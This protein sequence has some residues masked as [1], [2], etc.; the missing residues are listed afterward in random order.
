MTTQSCTHTTRSTLPCPPTPLHTTSCAEYKHPAALAA[1]KIRKEG[2]VWERHE[3]PVASSSG[4]RR[5]AAWT[6]QPGPGADADAGAGSGGEA[7]RAEEEPTRRRTGTHILDE[8]IDTSPAKNKG[9]TTASIAPGGSRNEH[10]GAASA[11]ED[12][13]RA[14]PYPA[15]RE[16]APRER[17]ITVGEIMAELRAGEDRS[18]DDDEPP[19]GRSREPRRCGD[20]GARSAASS[21]YSSHAGSPK[22]G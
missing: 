7:D 6:G 4:T 14:P 5:A 10:E 1:S 21:C 3:T 15:G 2:G 20:E 16:P 18:D 22:P 19:R 17:Y 8:E 12:E 11:A 13:D 9:K